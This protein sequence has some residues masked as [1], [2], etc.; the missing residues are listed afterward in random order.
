[1]EIFVGVTNNKVGGYALVRGYNVRKQGMGSKR[2]SRI[3][4]K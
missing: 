2:N 4:R 3:F 1:V